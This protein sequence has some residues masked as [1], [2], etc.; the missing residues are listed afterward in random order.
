[1]R[2]KALA[3]DIYGTLIDT[4]GLH[5]QLQQMGVEDAH[6]VLDLWRSKQLEY[7][8][9]RAAMGV[10]ASFSECT[11]QALSWVCLQKQVLDDAQQKEILDLYKALPAFQD[12]FTLEETLANHPI[13]AVAFS[14][15]SLAAV[16]HLLEQANLL[17]VFS[18][19]VSVES[20]QTFKPSP[21]VYKHLGSCCRCA[22]GEIAL[23]SSNPFDIVGAQHAG[24]T[25][26]WLRR[27]EKQHFD[28]W[29][30]PHYT[31]SSLQDLSLI[32]LAI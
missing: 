26:I 24:M 31:I 11:K 22:L 1:M 32:G 4:H 5:I 6:A 20:V 30:E 23:V 7:T 29:C 17:H 15:G 27:T 13:E 21:I 19:I 2:V 28:G 16:R 10:Y 25:G 9:R 12:C 14:N 8:F 18:Q 3:F